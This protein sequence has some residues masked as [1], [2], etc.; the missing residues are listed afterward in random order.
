[1]GRFFH[2]KSILYVKVVFVQLKF[3]KDLP[4]KDHWLACRERSMSLSLL[5]SQKIDNNQLE[6]MR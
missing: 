4:A 2:Q 5:G 6:V 3:G 1:L